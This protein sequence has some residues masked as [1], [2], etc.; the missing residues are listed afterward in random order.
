MKGKKISILINP[1]CL[2]IEIGEVSCLSDN[3]LVTS[4]SLWYTLDK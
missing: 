2:V 3:F 1:D 4:L